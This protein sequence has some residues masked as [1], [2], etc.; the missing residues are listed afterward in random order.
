L[1]PNS[2][3]RVIIIASK[4]RDK[5]RLREPN[6][7]A[8]AKLGEEE[9]IAHEETRL[10]AWTRCPVPNGYGG[11]EDRA[12]GGD[13]RPPQDIVNYAHYVLP[14]LMFLERKETATVKWTLHAAIRRSHKALDPPP[15]VDARHAPWALMEIVRRASPE[16]AKTVD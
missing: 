14:D 16:R 10:P 7:R 13:R 5:H 15:C 9:A 12:C 4:C 1:I 3:P 11:V 2:G 8:E 6:Q